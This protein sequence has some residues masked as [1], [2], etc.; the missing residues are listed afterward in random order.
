M[1]FEAPGMLWLLLVLP[2]IIL[3]YILLLRRQKKAAIRFG[4]IALLKDAL[5]PGQKI[6]HQLSDIVHRPSRRRHH[7]AVAA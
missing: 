6:R 1:T 2:L 3:A 7:P 4:N 5:G